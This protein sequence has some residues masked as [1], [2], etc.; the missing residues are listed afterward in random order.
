MNDVIVLSSKWADGR[1]DDL[2][3]QPDFIVSETKDFMALDFYRL[4][5]NRADASKQ[6]LK[7]FA[8]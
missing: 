3:H 8:H 1:P 7:I 6:S 5:R 4:R 2:T